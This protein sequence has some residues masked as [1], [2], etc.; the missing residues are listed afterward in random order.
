[1]F[2]VFVRRREEGGRE[3]GRRRERGRVEERGRG[4]E[5]GKGRR[6]RQREGGGVRA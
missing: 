6:D 3:G 4:E 5:R 1:M 2:V